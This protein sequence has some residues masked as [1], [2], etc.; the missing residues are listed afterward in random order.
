MRLN[1]IECLTA[2]SKVLFVFRAGAR[3]E[4]VVCRLALHTDKAMDNVVYHGLKTTGVRH[5][6]TSM[7]LVIKS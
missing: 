1:Q 5:D 7:D 4:P 3:A 6:K 2:L